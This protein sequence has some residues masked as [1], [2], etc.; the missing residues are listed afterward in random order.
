MNMAIFAYRS[1]AKRVKGGNQLEQNLIK[2]FVQNTIK[3]ERDFDMFPE[4][5]IVIL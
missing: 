5:V 3:L 1:D 2:S 4:M